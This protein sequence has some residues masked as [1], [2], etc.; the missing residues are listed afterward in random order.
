MN[1]KGQETIFAKIGVFVMVI[2]ALTA[3]LDPLKENTIDARS[4]GKLDCENS[5]ISTGQKA[6]CVIVDFNIFYFFWMVLAAAGGFIAVK[7][8]KSK[9]KNR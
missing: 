8:V 2:L 6:A 1:K 3:L 4:A 9:T 7:I 5:S